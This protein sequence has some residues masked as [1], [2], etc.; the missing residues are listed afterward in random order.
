[1]TDVTNK[2]PEAESA[3]SP[4]WSQ[5]L[6]RVRSASQSPVMMPA[7]IVAAIAASSSP[8]APSPSVAFD[9]FEREF[10]R[11]LPKAAGRAWLPF[12]ALG[13]SGGLWALEHDGEPVAPDALKA[14][15]PRSRKAFLTAVSGARWDT[16]LFESL[17]AEGGVSAVLAA[18]RAQLAES[19]SED[20][21]AVAALLTKQA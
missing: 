7:A 20:S 10:R 11:L 14:A 9:A 5:A 13:R 8:G 16:E 15:K 19:E 2:T 4:C 6:S 3:L 17:N 21:Q 1:M 18:I 12:L